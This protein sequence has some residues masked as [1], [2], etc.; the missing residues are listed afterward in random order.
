MKILFVIRDMVV[1]GAG[2]QLALT[3][4]ALSAKGHNVS[5][6]TYFGGALQHSL[7]EGVEYIAQNPVPRNKI[8][9]YF[10]SPLNIRKQIKR[11][12]PDVV[13]SWRCNAG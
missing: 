6:Y 11:L 9:E 1:G 8:A 7:N 10:F 12:R 3:A 13:I 2:K 4:N 5:V